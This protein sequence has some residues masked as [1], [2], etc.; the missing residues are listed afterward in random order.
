MID[1]W[2]EVMGLAQKHGFITMAYGGVAILMSH[3]N[4]KEQGIFE[5]T[6]A[7][8]NKKDEEDDWINVHPICAEKEQS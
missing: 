5:K 2:D 7:M 6:Q 4:Q 1:N 8:N 3:E